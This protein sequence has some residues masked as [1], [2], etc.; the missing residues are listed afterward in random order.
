MEGNDRGVLDG[1]RSPGVLALFIALAVAGLAIVLLVEHAEPAA[2]QI[3]IG[4]LICSVLRSF[5]AVF[6]SLFVGVFNSVLAA[7][8]CA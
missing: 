4:S 8:G 6:G 7:F 1:G 5:A 3:S 2:A